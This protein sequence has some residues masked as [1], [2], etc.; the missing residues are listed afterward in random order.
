MCAIYGMK[1]VEGMSERFE[2]TND[3]ESSWIFMNAH[4]FLMRKWI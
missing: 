1:C 4:D 3:R 2:Y